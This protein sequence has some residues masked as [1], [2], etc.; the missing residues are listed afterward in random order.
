MVVVVVVVIDDNDFGD[1]G[2]AVVH[3]V[4]SFD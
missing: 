2:D 4:D 1:D 3:Y